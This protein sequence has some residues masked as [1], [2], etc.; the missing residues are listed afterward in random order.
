MVI[1]SN[2]WSWLRRAVIGWKIS[3]QF[4]N[5]WKAKAI[6]GSA[7]S[8][9]DWSS[10]YYGVGF[11]IVIWKPLHENLPVK[12]FSL[13]VTHKREAESVSTKHAFLCEQH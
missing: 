1:Q 8:C 6:A 4:F 11:S 12:E 13:Q 10:S 9:C 2:Y 3:R 5:Q 7:Y